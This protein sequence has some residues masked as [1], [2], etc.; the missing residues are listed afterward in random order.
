LRPERAKLPILGPGQKL[1]DLVFRP[2]CNLSS[3]KNWQI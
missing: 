2:C 1:L 3:T